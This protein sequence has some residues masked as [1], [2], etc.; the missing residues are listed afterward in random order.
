[1]N[2]GVQQN[3]TKN[4]S[5]SFSN[6]MGERTTI[7]FIILVKYVFRIRTTATEVG[8]GGGDSEEACRQ[9]LFVRIVLTTTQKDFL[10]RGGERNFAARLPPKT[11]SVEE[12]RLHGLCTPTP[13][14]CHAPTCPLDVG[15]D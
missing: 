3:F 1:M 10:T 6:K 12:S 15:S 7:F 13:P 2:A 11:A 8:D 5:S 4:N 14:A 9:C